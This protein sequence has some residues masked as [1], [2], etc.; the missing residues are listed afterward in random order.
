MPTRREIIEQFVPNSPFAQRAGIRI[1]RIEPDQ[2]ELVMPFDDSLATM[3]DVVHGGAIATL[4][5][6]AA[7]A[8][9]W[10][11]ESEPE[12]LA[13]A[14]VALSIDY[15]AAARG[16]DLT[17][18][19]RGR[20]A[21]PDP[22]LPRRRRDGCRG[23]SD[24]EGDRDVSL[25]LNGARSPTGWRALNPRVERRAGRQR[26]PLRAARVAGGG[27]VETQ[28]RDHGER[29]AGVRVDGDPLARAGLAPA[30]EAAGVERGLEELRADERERDGAG[31]VVAGVEDLGVAAAVLVR[32]ADDAV[33]GVDG[34]VDLRR[35]LGRSG[36][37]SAGSSVAV[38]PLTNRRRRRFSRLAL[39]SAA[40]S[41]WAPPVDSATAEG[42]PTSATTS[43]SMHATTGVRPRKTTTP[44][45][46]AYGVS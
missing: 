26:G 36:G 3:G 37:E 38:G 44:L 9:A 35:G 10:A 22:V 7:M 28:A 17:A 6:T 31:A 25:R 12:A 8:A 29:V 43:I 27:G 13:G 15:V 2:A 33:G 45:S 16:T 24:R 23:G 46:S 19:A 34:C 21:R 5:D 1:E 18:K 30:H 14:T 39:R 4:A 41:N 20:P 32:L 42:A 40:D 11:D